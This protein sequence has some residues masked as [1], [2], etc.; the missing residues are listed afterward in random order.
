[1]YLASSFSYRAQTKFFLQPAHEPFDDVSSPVRLVIKLFL[2]R[3]WQWAS[4][5]G[6]S[7]FPMNL[8]DSHLRDQAD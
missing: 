6:S 8:P 1:M 5:A 7:A 4:E 3:L 2:L